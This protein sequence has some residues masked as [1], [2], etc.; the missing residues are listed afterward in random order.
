MNAISLGTVISLAAMLGLGLALRPRPRR[1][2]WSAPGSS[3][4]IVGV[5]IVMNAACIGYFARQATGGS[6]SCRT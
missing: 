3:I 1:S 4:L 2:P 6:T 5:Y